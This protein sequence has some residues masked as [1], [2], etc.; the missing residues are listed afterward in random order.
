MK[1]GY[2]DPI[3]GERLQALAQ[4]TVLTP[5]IQAFHASLSRAGVREVVVFRGTHMELEPDAATIDRLRGRRS[6]FVYSHLLESF[7]QRVLPR[8]DHQF[9]LISHNSDHGV[10][11]R[12][13]GALD[14]PRIAHWFAQNAIAN[15]Q[16]LT[17]LPIGVANA[18]WPHGDLRALVEVAG[19]NRP[20]PKDVV[21]VN[22]E[23]R[24]N[25]AVRIPL[26]QR[27][28][29][30]PI[31]RR[32]PP[33]PFA[34]YLA[35]MASCRWVISPPGNGVDCHRTWESLYLGITPI[36]LKTA[37]GA[38]LHD[39]LPIIQLPDLAA[40]DSAELEQAERTLVRDEASLARI[41]MGYWRDCI[42]EK[43]AEAERA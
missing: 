16:K 42:A 10:D 30:L 23:V 21:Y 12:F 9:V 41:K 38:S 36:V 15:H 14:D 1:W 22:F 19:V 28:Q 17:A 11:E 43:V 37:H 8:L 6:I 34:A 7:V 29:A 27:L 3:T 20:R 32:A 33:L 24:T 39:G 26:L 40:L 5:S 4:V 13:R 2:D 18:Q 31:V 35:D 25:P